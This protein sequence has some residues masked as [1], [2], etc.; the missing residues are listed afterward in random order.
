MNKLIPAIHHMI[1]INCATPINNDYE[2]ILICFLIN[3]KTRENNWP[4]HIFHL[5]FE[6]PPL[7]AILFIDIKL[8][9]DILTHHIYYLNETFFVVRNF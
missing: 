9:E 1:G 2:K 7:G 5:R 8:G 6:E 4:S 3:K